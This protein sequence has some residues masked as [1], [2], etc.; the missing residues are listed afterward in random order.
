MASGACRSAAIGNIDPSEMS[1]VEKQ[2]Y[3]SPA[4]GITV[5]QTASLSRPQTPTSSKR[6]MGDEA[7]PDLG[8]S[9]GPKRLAR[10]QMPPEQ[11]RQQ[12]MPTDELAH[13]VHKLLLQKEKDQEY[14]NQ[15][16]KAV[17]DHATRIIALTQWCGQ[18]GR[19][20]KSQALLTDD[21]DWPERG[22]GDRQRQPD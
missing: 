6:R 1:G 18:L 9:P 22:G 15:I 5:S 14:F 17:G 7:S 3:G 12:T 4:K 20:Q 8:A 10:Q 16:S 21:K 2:G 19:A 11:S 13:E